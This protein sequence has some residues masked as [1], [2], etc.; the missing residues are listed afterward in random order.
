MACSSVGLTPTIDNDV[1]IEEQS[2]GYIRYQSIEG[3]RWEVY[4]TCDYR[5]DCMVGA[6]EPWPPKL[7]ENRL[8]IPVTPEFIGCCPFTYVELTP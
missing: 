8:D 5:G 1:F 6:I 4:G 3:R 2:R 7:R